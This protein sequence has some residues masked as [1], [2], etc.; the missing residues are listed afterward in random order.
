LLLN[1]QKQFTNAI[2]SFAEAEKLAMDDPE[3]S[4]LSSA[5]YFSYGSASERAGD[6]EKAASLFRKAIDL[7]PNNHN[8]YNYLGYMWA[9]KGVHLDESMQLIQKALKLE[10]DNGAYLDSLGWVLYRMGRYEEAL[11]N[12]RRAVTLLKKEDE[13][14]D[15]TV[16]NHLAEVLLKLGKRDE[17]VDVWRRALKVDPDN[18]DIAGKLQ[19]YSADHTA[20]PTSSAAPPESP[21]R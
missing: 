11:P 15:S 17:A 8:A 21:T 16:L 3:E 2:A 6:E 10:P 7:D 13:Q 5:F 20:V 12:L 18:K 14:E 4:K 19:K 1:D 9:D